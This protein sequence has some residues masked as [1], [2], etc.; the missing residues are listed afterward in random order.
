ME[1]KIIQERS[2]KN[3]SKKKEFLDTLI[4]SIGT[5]QGGIETTHYKSV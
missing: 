3:S 2:S 1:Q 5:F 4:S